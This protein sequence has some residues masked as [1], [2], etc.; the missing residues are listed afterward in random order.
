MD[1]R[2][3]KILKAL[4]ALLFWLAAWAL[5]S[6]LVARPLLLPG[7]AAVLR[8]LWALLGE[9]VFWSCLLTSL[10]RV[11]AG[12]LS[13]TVLGVLLSALCE[14]FALAR[15]LFAPLLTAVKSTPVASFTILVLLWLRRELVPA[16]IAALIV[17]PVVFANVSA[18]IRAIDPRLLELAKVCRLGYWRTLRRVRVPSVLPQLRSALRSALGFGWKAGVAAEVLTLPEKSI[19]RQIYEAKLYLQTEELFAWTL[20]VIAVSL[21]LERALL[22]L[23]G[24]KEDGHA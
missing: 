12:V 8:R 24:G 14:R 5:L 7:P 20:A 13:A 21:L 16:F 15:T 2:W 18:G 23:L 4:A 10:L 22:F 11:L 6:H 1:E 19:G 17:L 3:K 9:G